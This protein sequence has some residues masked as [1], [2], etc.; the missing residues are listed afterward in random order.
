MKILK[1]NELAG[2]TYKSVMDRVGDKGDPKSARMYNDARKLRSQYYSKEPLKILLA[3][4]H[5]DP[6]WD[7]MNFKIHDISFF[8]D[9]LRISSIIDRKEH[10]LFFNLKDKEFIYSGIE[11]PIKAYVD[12]RSANVISKILKDYDVDFKPQDMP[13]F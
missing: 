1:F 11:K 4:I 12:R 9:V 3:N 13:Q 2:A 5:Q 6:E 8:N 7:S 10:I